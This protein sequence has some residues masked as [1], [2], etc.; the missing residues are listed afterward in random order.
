MRINATKFKV[1]IKYIYD[2]NNIYN[3]K[4]ESQERIE[5]MRGKKKFLSYL[6]AH[7]TGDEKRFYRLLK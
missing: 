4:K 3:G 1:E 6:E 7:I 5:R 2:F